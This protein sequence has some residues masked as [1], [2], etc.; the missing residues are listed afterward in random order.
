MIKRESYSQQALDALVEQRVQVGDLVTVATVLDR[1]SWAANDPLERNRFCGAMAS[2]VDQGILDR[3]PLR[4]GAFRLYRVAVELTP[5]TR[6]RYRG[7]PLGL[8]Y[9][10]RQPK[11]APDGPVTGALVKPTREEELEAEATRERA[12]ALSAVRTRIEELETKRA[13]MKASNAAYR[14]GPAAWAEFLGVSAEREQELR[15]TV[16][17]NHSWDRQPWPKY[18]I[19]NLGANIRR[20]KKRLAG[21]GGDND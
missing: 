20:L 16:E 2:L 7:R 11:A 14:K 10:P 17:D 1:V 6:P 3:E 9:T 5:D 12:E 13:R 4:E 15:A 18:E 19:S 21:L 8:K